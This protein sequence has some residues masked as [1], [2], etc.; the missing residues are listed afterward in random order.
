MR[1]TPQNAMYWKQMLISL[2]LGI[3][4][5]FLALITDSV[6]W[7]YLSLIPGLYFFIIFVVA[8][9]NVDAKD[10]G[11]KQNKKSATTAKGPMVTRHRKQA[12]KVVIAIFLLLCMV[13]AIDTGDLRW[14]ILLIITFLL[15]VTVG[16]LT[17]HKK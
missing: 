11:T 9:S 8:F 3:V 12:L 5:N 1:K 2:F 16:L 15:F 13:C 14:I 6:L 10:S 7:T 4:L 17:G